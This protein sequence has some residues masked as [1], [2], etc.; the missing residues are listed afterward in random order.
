MF[1]ILDISPF[2]IAEPRKQSGRAQKAILLIGTP[3]IGFLRENLKLST[4]K[5]SSKQIDFEN[6]LKK[7]EVNLG[8]IFHKIKVKT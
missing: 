8:K 5:K 2:P 3:Y 4:K 6:D 7:E 1:S